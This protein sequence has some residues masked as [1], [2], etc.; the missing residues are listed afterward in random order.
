VLTT[1]GCAA[2]LMLVTLVASLDRLV[3]FDERVWRAVLLARGCGTDVFVE[4]ALET[5][6][7]A[8]LALLVVVVV[9]HVRRH[10]LA[11]AWPWIMACGLGLLASRTLKHILTRERP[12]SLPDVALGYSFPSAHVMNSLVALLAVIALTH[13]VRHRRLWLA[14]AASLF[15][16]VTA[17]RILLGRHWALDVVGGLLAALAFVGFVVPL[18]DRRH[19]RAPVSLALGLIGLFALDNW[20]GE[21]GMRLPAPLV[22]ARLALDEVDIGPDLRAPLA[23]GW[24]EAAVERPGGSL[25]WLEGSG[26]IRIDIA[27]GESGMSGTG[28]APPALRLALAGRPAKAVTPCTTMSVALNGRTLGRFVPFEGWREYRLPIPPDLVRQGPNELA[29]ESRTDE[30]PSRFAVASVRLARALA[31]E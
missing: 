29:I 6:T 24:R 17:G 27:D 15:V 25:V 21:G 31:D 4:H 11:S 16:T 7:K 19:V 28:T 8:L 22:G 10:G 13:A 30:G 3:G 26:T 5:A 18:V 1:V 20:I 2:A 12:S 14:V 9:L 23:G